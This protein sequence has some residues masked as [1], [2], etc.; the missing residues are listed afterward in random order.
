MKP[1]RVRKLENDHVVQI[2]HSSWENGAEYSGKYGWP[3]KLGRLSRG[4]E[5]PVWVLPQMLALAIE[6]HTV[7][8]N[9][10]PAADRKTLRA[11]FCT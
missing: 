1:I 8:L 10:I 9:D 5:V 6:E 3:N 4:G 2:G 7:S 11:F